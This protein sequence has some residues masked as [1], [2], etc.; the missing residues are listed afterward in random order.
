MDQPRGRGCSDDYAMR[1]QQPLPDGLMMRMGVEDDQAGSYDE[2]L[3]AE[4]LD[5]RPC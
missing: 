5:E 3:R 2:I 1:S 4:A